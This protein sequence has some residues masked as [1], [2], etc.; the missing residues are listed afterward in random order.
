M[1]CGQQPLLFWFGFLLLN[2]AADYLYQQQEGQFGAYYQQNHP[3][4][5]HHIPEPGDRDYRTYTFNNRRYGQYP[6]YD[7]YSR[8]QPGDPRR[9]GQDV[10]FSYDPVSKNKTIYLLS[11]LTNYNI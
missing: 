10:R 11:A 2:C 8:G 9:V 1:A 3:Y 7:H 5:R 4:N 6:P